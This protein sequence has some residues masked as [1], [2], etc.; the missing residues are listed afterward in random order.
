MWKLPIDHA[1]TKSKA[2]TRAEYPPAP[3]SPMT[4]STSRMENERN[5]VR[6]SRN[7]TLIGYAQKSPRIPIGFPRRATEYVTA[8]R[9]AGAAAVGPVTSK[10]SRGSTTGGRR[11]APLACPP[12]CTPSSVRRARDSPPS[13]I[14]PPARDGEDLDQASTW[15]RRDFSHCHAELV[16]NGGAE[17]VCSALENWRRP[18]RCRKRGGMHTRARGAA[19]ERSRRPRA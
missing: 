15:A 6:L 16:L 12:C 2:S 8:G 4:T 17:G 18:Q 10:L 3:S 13:T 14:R 5:S 1:S 9:E 19:S 7:P 11:R